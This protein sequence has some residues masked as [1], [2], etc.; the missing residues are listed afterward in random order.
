MAALPELLSHQRCPLLSAGLVAV[1]LDALESLSQ[2]R[3]CQVEQHLRIALPV[4]EHRSTAHLVA[5]QAHAARGSRTL[6]GL[7]V[8][9]MTHTQ[10]TQGSFTLLPMQGEVR[11]L[12]HADVAEAHQ[13]VGRHHQY[14]NVAIEVPSAVYLRLPGQ[15]YLAVVGHGSRHCFRPYQLLHRQ[16]RRHRGKGTRRPPGAVVCAERQPQALAFV[17]G[18]AHEAAPVVGADGVGRVADDGLQR[19]SHQKLLHATNARLTVGFEVGSD[20]FARHHSVH[21]LPDHQRTSLLR[22]ILKDFVECLRLAYYRAQEGQQ[23]RNSSS[24]HCFLLYLIISLRLSMI[25]S[26]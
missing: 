26:P 1:Y 17:Q 15:G 21:P 19:T 9:G 14:G 2:S 11:R 13:A 24:D 7:T 10:H 18:V 3:P 8:G 25:Y 20:A 23:Q 4:A 12:Q 16:L 5:L 6:V 22:R